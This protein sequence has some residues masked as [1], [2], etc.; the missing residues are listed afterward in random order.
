MNE[1]QMGQD[2]D[3]FMDIMILVAGVYM[4]YAGLL[5]KSTG[6]ITKS[7]VSRNI[8][9]DNA[10]EKDKYIKHMFLPTMLIGIMMLFC[11]FFPMIVPQLNITLPENSSIVLYL[12]SMGLIIAFGV[13]SLN[14]QNRYLK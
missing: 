9:I 8:D 7:F 5:M 2:A 14:M 13:Y 6:K 1:A 12:I 4:V 3:Y 11:G 10:P